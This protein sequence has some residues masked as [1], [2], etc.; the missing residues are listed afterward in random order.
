MQQ[1]NAIKRGTVTELLLSAH[2]TSIGCTVCLPVSHSQSY[3]MII[4][5]ELYGLARIQVKRCFRSDTNTGFRIDMA[6]SSGVPYTDDSFDYVAT[7]TPDNKWVYIIPQSEIKGRY[8]IKVYGDD[9]VPPQQ[10]N[11]LEKYRQKFSTV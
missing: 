5:G 3:D 7:I 2:F 11:S 8:K 10:K 9:T 6:H 1:I 4:D